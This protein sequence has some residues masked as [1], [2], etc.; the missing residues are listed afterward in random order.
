MLAMTDEAGIDGKLVAVPVDKL[1]KFYTRTKT[2]EDLPQLM[3][4]QIF[5]FFSH[6]KDLEEGKWVKLDGWRGIDE[7]RQEIMEGV[8]RYEDHEHPKPKF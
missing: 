5:H 3:L 4:D 2:V 6:Y 1:T 7:A 8:K